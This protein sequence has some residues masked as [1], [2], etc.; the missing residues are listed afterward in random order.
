MAQAPYAV[1]SEVM[2][3]AAGLLENEPERLLPW[4]VRETGSAQGKAGFD[5]ALVISELRESTAAASAPF[6]QLLRSIKP[7]LPHDRSHHREIIGLW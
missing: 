3:R 5:L 1:R 2:L 7:R 6:G 4:L